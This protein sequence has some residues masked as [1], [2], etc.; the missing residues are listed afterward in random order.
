M[1][2]KMKARIE[3]AKFLQLSVDQAK[4][5]NKASISSSVVSSSSHSVSSSSELVSKIINKVM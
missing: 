1:L 3:I 2:K 4:Q 5:E